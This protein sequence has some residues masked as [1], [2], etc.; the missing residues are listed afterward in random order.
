[1]NH[2]IVTCSLFALALPAV[3][4]PT[5][6]KDVA[7]ILFQHCAACH[8]PG[9][10]APFSL[11]TYKDAAKRAKHLKEV[12]Q[13]RRMPPWMP[14]PGPHRFLDE[15]RLSDAQLK[16]LAEWVD[17]G[18]P[19]GDAKDLPSLPKFADGW[20]LGEPDL[21]VEM[22]ESFTVPADGP[23]IYQAFVIPL[24]VE[25]LK[26]VKAVEFRPGTR[27]VVHHATLLLDTSGEMRQRDEREAGPGFLTQSGLD[28]LITLQQSGGQFGSWTPGATPRF[29]PEGV[30]RP[31]R[32]KTDLV[33]MIHYHPSGKPE[34]DRSKLGIFFT[35]KPNTAAMTT[36]PLAASPLAG[37]AHLLDIPAGEARHEVRLE[38]TM[39]GAARVF[40]VIPH[41]HY[42]LRE[43]KLTATKPGGHPEQILWI[44]DWDFNWQ[45][46]YAFAEPPLLPAGTRIELVARFDNSDANPQNPNHP[47]KPVR[48]GQNSTDEM[49]STHLALMP[50][51]AASLAAFQPWGARPG[52]SSP[53]GESIVPPG[54]VPIPER[55]R[56]ML[57]RFD[58]DA[59][60]KLTQKEID[61]MPAQLRTA[62]LERIRQA[63]GGGS[64]PPTPAATE[65]TKPSAQTSPTAPLQ[66]AKQTLD[67]TIAVRDVEKMR[68]F[69]GSILG[70]TALPEERPAPNARVYPYRFGTTV[71]RLTAFDPAPPASTHAKLRDA[72]G[73]RVLTL[74]PPDLAAIEARAT[75]VGYPAWQSPMPGGPVR[76][77]AD[78]DGN[79]V[80]L[81]DGSRA[82]ASDA[83]LVQ[84][85]GVMVGLIA[86][87]AARSRAFYENVLGFPLLQER[88]SRAL[89]VPGYYLKAGD[90][91]VKFWAIPGELPT[92]AGAPAAHSGYRHLTITVADLEKTKAALATKGAPFIESPVA[93]TNSF[94]AADPD[95]NRIQFVAQKLP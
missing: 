55:A 58:T 21:V 16:T 13:E 52:G 63:R 72:C 77:W 19:E 61:A 18:A 33:M 3:A 20:Q 60:G 79:V 30:A 68:A 43:L 53:F 2:L 89:G 22:P 69:Y 41:A 91:I 27:R 10:V 24:P 25:T 29:L 35:D 11:L 4:A 47:P 78:P 87:D 6:T 76:M 31:L 74:V 14:E 37:N 12:T 7:P 90:T 38:R 23:D 65:P 32:P 39:P 88:P 71:L 85:D 28:L 54:G 48:Y 45:D 83:G 62:L 36:L 92:T 86:R 66:L 46:R 81:I 42:L 67:L 9:E 5:F 82:A 26:W 51:D 57:K 73:Y 64:A 40:G 84:R 34:Q 70:L 75:R 56:A 50:V 80:E 44:K 49:L 8:R 93:E 17:A 1:M 15:R 94:W 95:G 59:D